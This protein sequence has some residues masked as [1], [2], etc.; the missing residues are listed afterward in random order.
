L[1]GDLARIFH[2]TLYRFYGHIFS[3]RDSISILIG[4][5][6]DFEAI[7]SIQLTSPLL[8]WMI[9]IPI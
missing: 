5:L 1:T 3:F 2:I 4:D 6:I 8:F 7:H 9:T